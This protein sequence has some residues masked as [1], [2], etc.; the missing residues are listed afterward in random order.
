[1]LDT[2]YSLFRGRT[3]IAILPISQEV[4]ILDANR[5]VHLLSVVQRSEIVLVILVTR[6]TLFGHDEMECQRWKGN[7]FVNVSRDVKGSGEG[8]EVF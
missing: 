1:M 2:I 8:A 5:V 3:S 6:Y 4:R 7:V